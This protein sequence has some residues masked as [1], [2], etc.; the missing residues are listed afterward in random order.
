[1]EINKIYFLVRMN[2]RFLKFNII[3]IV[4]PDAFKHLVGEKHNTRVK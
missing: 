3:F 1:M 2:V 4:S